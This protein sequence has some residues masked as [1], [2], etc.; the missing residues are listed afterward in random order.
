MVH[1]VGGVSTAAQRNTVERL[2][3]EVPGVTGVMNNVGVGPHT[4]MQ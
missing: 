3:R 2:I 1:V 4:P